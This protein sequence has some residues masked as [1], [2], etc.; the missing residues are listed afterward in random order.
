[1]A[2]DMHATFMRVGG[3]GCPGVFQVERILNAV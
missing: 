3:Q 2:V 1:M